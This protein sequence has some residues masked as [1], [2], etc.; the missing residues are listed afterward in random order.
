VATG[1]FLASVLTY[2]Q[3]QS[4]TKML[5]YP[6]LDLNRFI[7]KT[8]GTLKGT[9]EDIRNSLILLGL[10]EEHKNSLNDLQEGIKLTRELNIKESETLTKQAQYDVTKQKK[11]QYGRKY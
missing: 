5:K 10:L 2:L 3:S 7:E 4:A 1:A 11:N 8:I 6:E 9:W